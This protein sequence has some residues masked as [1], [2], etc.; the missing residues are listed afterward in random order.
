MTTINKIN[1]ISG[2]LVL[3][4]F[5]FEMIVA[6]LAAVYWSN[7]EENIYQFTD[8]IKLMIR[9]DQNAFLYITDIN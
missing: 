5:T 9:E 8:R 1:F 2:V 4:G 3:R 6:D 7:P